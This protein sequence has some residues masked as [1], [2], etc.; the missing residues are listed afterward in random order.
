MSNNNIKPNMSGGDEGEFA[1]YLRSVAPAFSPSSKFKQR[2]LGELLDQVACQK[3]HPAS[4][5]KKSQKL[6]WFIRI[7]SAAAACI[8]ISLGCWMLL[9]G[10]VHD[11]SAG[12]AEMVKNVRKM[13]NVAFNYHVRTADGKINNGGRFSWAYPGQSRTTYDSGKIS[14]RDDAKEIQLTLRPNIMQATKLTYEATGPYTE[15]WKIIKLIEEA[16]GKHLGKEIYE[17]QEVDVYEA[18]FEDEDYVMK[19]WVTPKG[20]LPVK[21][22]TRVTSVGSE[23]LTVYDKFNWG[24]PFHDSLFSTTAPQGYETIDLEANP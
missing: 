22:E 14:I 20:E 12:F 5:P 24:T 11:A 4:K 10:N 2:L 13:Q 19:I 1:Q 18:T 7:S 23:A 9:G 17:G 8:A 16:S 6:T 15:I 3:E 21:I